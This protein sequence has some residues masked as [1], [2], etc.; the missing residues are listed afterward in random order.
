MSRCLPRCFLQLNASVLRR[1]N[2]ILTRILV[3]V[4][5]MLGKEHIRMNN[6]WSVG[7]V[8][9]TI[10]GM[11][12]LPGT[13]DRG[14]MLHEAL[15]QTVVERLPGIWIP[16]AQCETPYGRGKLLVSALLWP[17]TSTHH[18][19]DD[20]A[21]GWKN[22]WLWLS[23]QISPRLRLP[24]T[25]HFEKAQVFRTSWTECPAFIC[26]AK[27][28]RQVTYFHLWRSLHDRVVTRYY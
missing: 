18:S 1:I 23:C 22:E 19:V 9:L 20:L 16:A 26:G 8:G 15:G 24:V 6:K 12:D 7:T 2:N 11:L 13:V 21:K 27:T 4:G 25:A 28:L 3:T 10:W 17:V 5:L 14:E